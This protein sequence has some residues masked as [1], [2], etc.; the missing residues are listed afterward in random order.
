MPASVASLRQTGD[1][2]Q[3]SARRFSAPSTRHIGARGATG[4]Q[5][6]FLPD[7]EIHFGDGAYF[8]QHSPRRRIHFFPPFHLLFRVSLPDT[9]FC[10]EPQS[11]LRP[12]HFHQIFISD[13]NRMS[14]S[15]CGVPQMLLYTFRTSQFQPSPDPFVHLPLTAQLHDR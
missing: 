9:V 8:M 6:V 7:M 14:A 3:P 1:M 15:S 12:H 13:L 5:F 4:V 2:M 11:S 10:Q